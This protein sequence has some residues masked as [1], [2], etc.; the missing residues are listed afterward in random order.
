MGGLTFKRALE[1]CAALDRDVTI[2]QD[3]DGRAPADLRAGVQ[4]LLIDG[5]RQLFVGDPADGETLEP[6][7]VT[8]NG[9][10]ALRK[11][12]QLPESTDVGRW[13]SQNK[14]E[15]ALRI[16]DSAS[17]IAMPSYITE[18]VGSLA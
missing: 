4:D 9:E 17:S 10:D 14:T 15:A 12:L 2:L 8:A 16:H 6:Q 5:Q 11:V 13:M 7:L 1:V 18:A 3:N